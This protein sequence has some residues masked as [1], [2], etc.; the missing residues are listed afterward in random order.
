MIY[1]VGD[2]VMVDD[3]QGKIVWIDK[4]FILDGKPYDILVRIQFDTGTFGIWYR[5]SD[6]QSN[7]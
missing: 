6:I 1:K 4:P 7:I 5:I 2:L 3:K